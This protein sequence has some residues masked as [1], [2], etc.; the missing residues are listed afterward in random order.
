MVAAVALKIWWRHFE[1]AW[2]RDCL[3][4]RGTSAAPCL[5]KGEGTHG[6]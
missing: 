4:E 1:P 3:L 5:S 2:T 6:S